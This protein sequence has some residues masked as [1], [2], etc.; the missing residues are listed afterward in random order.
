MLRIGQR[1][2]HHLAH[3]TVVSEGSIQKEVP[4]LFCVHP[5]GMFCTGWAGC[6]VTTA[7]QHV[8]F[9][10]APSL[11]YNLMFRAL[12]SSIS[13]SEPSNKENFA[14]LLKEKK[15]LAVVPGGFEEATI[16]RYGSDRVWLRN[17]AGFIKMA[18]QTGHALRPVYA[19]GESDTYFNLRGFLKFR[20]WLN[21]F[22]LPGVVAFGAWWFPL[23]PRQ[24]K[25]HVVV[26]RPI[27]LPS[28]E[29]P[30][31]DDVRKWH[32]VYMKALQRLFDRHK[33]QYGFGE[34]QL[35]IWPLVAHQK[36]H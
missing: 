24:C 23:L 12:V 18:L 5:H 29:S 11:F 3:M 28:I 30:S 36:N 16:F 32:E 10:F 6:F 31:R 7:F 33:K 21:K 8:Y 14:R 2:A 9:C 13:N 26:G 35:E 1:A 34:R 19:F 4:T 27:Q 15:S 25:V 20:L 22:G 17:R